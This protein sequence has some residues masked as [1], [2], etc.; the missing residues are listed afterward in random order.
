M[1]FNNVSLPQ[2][3]QNG[4]KVKQ[5][6]ELQPPVPTKTQPKATNDLNLLGQLNFLSFGAKKTGKQVQAAPLPGEYPQ[7]KIKINA[8]KAL[9]LDV[10]REVQTAASKKMTGKPSWN[11]PTPNAWMVTAETSTFMKTGGLGDVAVDLPEAFN[12]TYNNDG[13]KMTIVQPLY[14]SGDL[15]KLENNG[16]GTYTYTSKPMGGKI[17][18]VDTGVKIDV[19]VGDGKTTEVTVLKGSLNGT[20]YRFLKNKEFFGELPN[21]GKKVSPYVENKSGVGESERFAFLSKAVAYYIKD[22]KENNPADAPNIIDANDWHAGPLAAQFK[23][24]M[25]AKAANNDGVSR[26]T[27]IE[28]QE[29][30][31]VYT[32]HNL[33]YQGWDHPNTSKILDLLYEDYAS[34]IFKNAYA[35]NMKDTPKSVIVRDT[36]NA[37][38]HG[39]SL[40]DAVIAVSPNY[41]KEIASQEF[42]GYDFVNVLDTRKDSGNLTGIVNGIGQEGIAPDGKLATKVYQKFPEFKMYNKDMSTQEIQAARKHNK[43]QFIK[44]LQ[45]GE[46]KERLGLD[47]TDGSKLDFLK[48]SDFDKTPILTVVSRLEGQKGPDLM[49]KSIKHALMQPVAKDKPLPVVVILGTG[50]GAEKLNELKKELPP[51]LSKRVVFFNAFSVDLMHM[52]QTAGDMFLMPSKFEP[53]GLGQLQAMAKGNVPVATAT[54][55]LADTIENG[56]T[57][58]L[59]VYHPQNPGDSKEDQTKALKNT[60]RNYNRALD[61]A[62]ATYHKSPQKFQQIALNALKEDFSWEE[63]GSLKKYLNLFQTGNTEES[64]APEK[65]VVNFY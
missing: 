9:P 55:G 22:L 40:A 62:L 11:I 38:I 54:G 35:P 56:K 34:S 5:N 48:P 37:A 50:G 60:S 8:Q 57:G 39:L 58:F 49:A 44:L 6:K 16:D 42:F 1:V 13:A 31:I 19:P 27:A 14:E 45:S 61:K 18:L 46:I 25:P 51:E 20:E 24:L 10:A 2:G 29:I 12:K 52:I 21:D 64:A 26:K 28:L 7:Y 63:S 23:Y 15:V 41:S 32:V 17:N 3:I 30:P 65:K 43:S 53:C 4:F 36:Y 59:S 33:E 47:S